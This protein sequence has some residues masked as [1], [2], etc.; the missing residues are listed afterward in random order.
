VRRYRPEEQRPPAPR[1]VT[2]GVVTRIEG[3]LE[4]EPELMGAHF[5]QQPMPLWDSERLLE[6]RTDHLAWMHSHFADE[7]LLYGSA[8]EATEEAPD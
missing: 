4:V 7:T 1:L 6:S 3:I 5:D 8:S 2:K